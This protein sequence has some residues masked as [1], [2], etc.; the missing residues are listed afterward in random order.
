MSG[1]LAKRLGGGGLKFLGLDRFLFGVS[2]LGL[3]FVTTGRVC[4][5]LAGRLR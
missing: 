5:D 4:A 1:R 3:I 2:R